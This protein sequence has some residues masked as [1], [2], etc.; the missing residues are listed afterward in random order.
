MA[1]PWHS[2]VDK[3]GIACGFKNVVVP[4]SNHNSIVGKVTPNVVEFARTIFQ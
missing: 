3:A 1:P 4:E 2:K